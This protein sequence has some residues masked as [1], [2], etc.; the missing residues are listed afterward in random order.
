MLQLGCAA[1]SAIASGTWMNVR[2]FP[3]EKFRAKLDDEIKRKATWYYSPTLLSEYKMASLDLADRHGVS[4]LIRPPIDC[5]SPHADVLF[6]GVQPSSVGWSETLAF[7]HYLSCLKQQCESV[8]AATFD[9]TIGNY[10]KR[11]D[12]AEAG[13]QQLHGLAITGQKRDFLACIDA[14]RG[15]LSLF[16]KDRG[17]VLRRKWADLTS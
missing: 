12:V 5:D 11:L 10:R 8:V 7:R 2:C 15:A 1:A 3:P 16:E 9:D 4:D 6:E 17:V 14:C 13:L